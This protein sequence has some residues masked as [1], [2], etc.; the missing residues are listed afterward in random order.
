MQGL[1]QVTQKPGDLAQ[2]R[3]RAGKGLFDYRQGLGSCGPVLC[4]PGG[5]CFQTGLLERCGAHIAA[6]ALE[7]MGCLAEGVHIAG[8]QGLAQLAHTQVGVAQK[9]VQQQRLRVVASTLAALAAP[10]DSHLARTLTSPAALPS[11]LILLRK[12]RITRPTYGIYQ[13]S[14]KPR[15]YAQATSG[16]PP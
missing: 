7:A 1:G 13:G 10:L 11:T 2:Q 4:Q 6:A 8:T 3:L 15:E 16:R 9:G 5:F 12:H 14:L